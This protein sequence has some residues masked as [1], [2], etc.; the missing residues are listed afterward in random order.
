MP[1]ATRIPEDFWAD[2]VGIVIFEPV[3]WDREALAITEDLTRGSSVIPDN[4]AISPEPAT[5]LL[6]ALGAMA[7]IRRRK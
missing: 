1:P 3:P 5:L 6:L 4:A 2:P 7:L